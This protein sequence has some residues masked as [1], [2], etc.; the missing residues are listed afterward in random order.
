M[1]SSPS[2]KSTS[3]IIRPIEVYEDE[4]AK[5]VEKYIELLDHNMKHSFISQPQDL[6]LRAN[7]GQDPLWFDLYDQPTSSNKV[8]MAV[9]HIDNTYF[10]QR[11]LVILH[12][13]TN[14]RTK[15]GE[16]LQKFVEFI[17]KNEEC[18]EIKISLYYIEDEQNN[19]GA[20]KQLQEFIK[21][22]GFRWKQLVNDKVTGKRYIDYLLKRPEGMQCEIP[23]M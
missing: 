18:D 14:D 4:I 1:T 15:Y 22:L 11:R 7:N 9:T 2:K 21:G 10:A 3:G 5:Y 16:S 13:S 19:L 6:L 20:D 8:G 12:F 17:W 23:K